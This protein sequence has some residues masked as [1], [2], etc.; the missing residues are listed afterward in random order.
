MRVIGSIGA[1]FTC[2]LSIIGKSER[3]LGLG[4]RAGVSRFLITGSWKSARTMVNNL[5]VAYVEIRVATVVSTVTFVLL[6]G[7][8]LY[9]IIE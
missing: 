9:Y 2:T 4:G 6:F 3:A 1:I 7:F 5:P 8:R